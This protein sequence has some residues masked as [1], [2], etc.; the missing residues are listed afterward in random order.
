[1]YITNKGEPVE[2]TTVSLRKK[3]VAKIR[4]LIKVRDKQESVDQLVAELIEAYEIL[5]GL[6]K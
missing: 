1:M 3:T 5:K 2:K 6:D 4:E